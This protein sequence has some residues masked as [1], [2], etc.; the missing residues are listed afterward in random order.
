MMDVAGAKHTVVF[1]ANGLGDCILTL[2]SLRALTRHLPTRLTLVTG[3]CPAELLFGDVGFSQIL[4]VPMSRVGYS[5]ARQFDAAELSRQLGDADYFISLV[6]WTS[7]ALSDVVQKSNF[8]ATFGF[9]PGF[10]FG[11]W[12]DPDKHAAD[13]TFDL[14]RK[15]KVDLDI[16]D[17]ANPIRLPEEMV[18]A[19]ARVR[20]AIGNDRKTL[21]VHEETST[22]SK[23]WDPIRMRQ[24]L[25]A[26]TAERRDLTPIIVS[27][28]GPSFDISGLE[29]QIVSIER[30]SLGF[31][32]ALI[33]DADVFVGVDS[34]GFHAADLWR[35]PAVG[36][37]GPTR[38]EEWGGRFSPSYRHVYGAGRMDDIYVDAVLEA[39]RSVLA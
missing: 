19:A 18:A 16:T 27:R 31:F 17:F 7:A 26:I 8:E 33:A 13:R 29:D 24:M 30:V 23:C 2:P 39:V 20:R 22:A 6:P 1:F 36:L 38:P 37:F 34:V 32:L 10:D 25:E 9:G 28:R 5:T 3:G 14:V 12:P 35:V 15:F 11:L 21:V 4:S